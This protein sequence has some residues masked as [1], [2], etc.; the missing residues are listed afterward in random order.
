[1]ASVL[2]VQDVEK[3]SGTLQSFYSQIIIRKLRKPF[4]MSAFHV[5]RSG[6]MALHRR[7]RNLEELSDRSNWIPWL[8]FQDLQNS[9]IDIFKGG[10]DGTRS[11][12][13]IRTMRGRFRAMGRELPAADIMDSSRRC[14]AELCLCS[15]F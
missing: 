5:E 7:C 8:S 12:T 2:C 9:S 3:L 14:S 13:Q 11:V 10:S 6:W 15:Q 4:E 1:M